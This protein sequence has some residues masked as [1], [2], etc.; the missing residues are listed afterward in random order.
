MSFNIQLNGLNGV[1][2]KIQ[3]VPKESEKV[4]EY[5]IKQFCND[6]VNDAKITAQGIGLPEEDRSG[7]VNGL[8]Y[9]NLTPLQATINV[10]YG[11][12]AYWEFGTGAFV[13]LADYYFTP[14]QRTYAAEFFVNGKGTIH[15][16]PYLF[17]AYEKNRIALIE[18]L[19]QLS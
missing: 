19:K 5:E 6:V 15:S 17:P 8:G 7:I 2:T 3:N 11:K 1:L 18:H 9:N 4:V 14:E 13:F 12:A 10:N 16:H